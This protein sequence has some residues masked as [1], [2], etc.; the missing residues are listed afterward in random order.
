[1][2]TCMSLGQSE[3]PERRSYVSVITEILLGD[4]E[5]TVPAHLTV[6]H[7]LGALAL[8]FFILQIVT[9]TLLMVYYRPSVAFAYQSIGTIMDDVRLGWLIHALHSRGADLLVLLMVLHMIRVYFSRAYQAP[10]QLNWAVGILLLLLVF[11]L[12]FTGTLLPWDQ[13]GYWATESARR[14]ILDIPG[15]GSLLLGL[16]WGGW[17]L[18]EEVLLR[19]YALHIGV[20]PWLAALLLF[21]HFLMVWRFGIK[22]PSRVPS[23]TRGDPIPLFPDYMLNLLLGALIIVGLLITAAVV[24]PPPLMERAD[25]LTDLTP[26]RQRWYLVPLA[27]LL[28]DLP[29]PITALVVF[30]LLLALLAIPLIDRGRVRNGW[31]KLVQRGVGILLIAVFFLLGLNGYLR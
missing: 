19:F 3:K 13:Y 24:Y 22:E 14:T 5:R 6:F 4:R 10:R 20:L 28:R 31:P 21:L 17:D 27:E 16:F 23:G 26:L 9:G 25:P 12:G 15:L 7:Y 2:V 1:M 8:V 18:G 29:E 30:F 11:A